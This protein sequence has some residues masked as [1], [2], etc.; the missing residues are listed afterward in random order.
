LA[1]LRTVDISYSL[2][3]IELLRKCKKM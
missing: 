1:M 2:Y 3:Q